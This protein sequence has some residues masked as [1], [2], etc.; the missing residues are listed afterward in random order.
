MK[1]AFSSNAFKN[2]NL[3][4]AV[5]SISELGFEGIEIMADIPH[6]YP[7]S[8][9]D[10]DI[11]AL[12]EVIRENDLEVSNL[13]AF[14]LFA[15][16]DVYHPSWIDSESNRCKRISHTRD[17]IDLANKIGAKNLSIEPG[18]PVRPNPK[19]RKS[20]EDLFHN[21]IVQLLR[22]AEEKKVKILIEP[23]PGL[24]IENSHEFLHFIER[25]DSSFVKLNFDIGH[26][27]CVGE[28]PSKLISLL[29]DYIE[30]IHLADIAANRVHNHLIPGEG[31][32]DF[33]SIFS[34]LIQ[35]DYQG[36][37]TIELYP[38]QNNP[39][40]AAKKGYKHII[41]IMDSLK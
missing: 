14:T 22:H 38:Y 33:K 20:Y 31:A 32:I 5:I 36:F 16:G 30:H 39:I 34:S 3:R 11:T 6:A 35:L 1:L 40:Y 18:G 21:G 10:N 15:I 13:N 41:D 23:E 9:T 4:D 17:C 25:F 19:Q 29:Y 28:D 27:F 12:A 8:L 2:Y 37:I 26:F 7:P 24:L